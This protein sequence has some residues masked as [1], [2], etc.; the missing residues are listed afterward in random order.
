MTRNEQL[1]L[2]ELSVA[3]APLS[4]RDVTHRCGM[5]WATAVKLMTR[6]E[7]QGYIVPSGNERQNQA[8]KSATVYSLS[9][10]R[11]AAIGIDIEYRRVRLTIWNLLGQCL[12]QSEL[13]TP[14]L[15]G[16]EGL[17]DFLETL[18]R[19]GASKAEKLGVALD[20]AGV[21][22]PS[23]LFGAEAVPY[24]MV[25]ERL[26]AHLGF[27]V[28]VDNN[29]RCFAA[30]IASL[31]NLSDSMLV[32][33]VRSGVGVGIVVDGRIYQGDKGSAGEIGHFPVEK[34][35]LPCR[36]GKSGCLETVVNR[37][38]LAESL[39]LAL[40]GD[41]TAR[42]RFDDL[43]E[44]L[45]KAIAL[46]MMMLDIRRVVIFAELGEYGVKLLDPLRK[47]IAEVAVPGFQCDIGYESLDANA[48]V[49]GAARL[50]LDKFVR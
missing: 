32:V 19:R 22:V 34:K 28:V 23:R 43:A 5:G 15:K 40:A 49:A 45:G 46:G 38:A 27:P 36:C 17:I 9:T 13:P 24:A 21:G 50:V 41:R 47:A 48:Y 33:T 14:V 44:Q 30:A 10:I 2:R 8:G 7:E 35:G 18:L 39:T 42:K 20:G 31:Q 25:G 3:G 11:P 29:I 16:P 12:F 4:K 1:I 6:L 37:D 26:S